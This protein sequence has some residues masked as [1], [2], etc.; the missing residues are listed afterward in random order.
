MDMD[1]NPRSSTI[2]CM[3]LGSAQIKQESKR[4]HG[5]RLRAQGSPHQDARRKDDD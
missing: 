1:Q 3:N 5:D 2:S 4:M